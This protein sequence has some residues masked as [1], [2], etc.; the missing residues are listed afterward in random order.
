MKLKRAKAYR[1]LMSYLQLNFQ[2][3][4][5]YQVLVDEEIVLTA[6]SSK[7]DLLAGLERTLQGKCKVL[8]SQCAIEHLYRAKTPEAKEAVK[9][10][11][12]FER[13]RCGHL[14]SKDQDGNKEN[15]TLS[16]FECICECVGPTNKHRYCVATQKPK[17]RARFRDIP[18]IPLI[19]INRA[20]MIMEPMSPA[21]AKVRK[22][23]E[24]SKLTKGLNDFGGVAA[25]NDEE[26]NKN[27]RVRKEK[28]PNPLS[29]KKRQRPVESETGDATD[30]KR[31]K[32]GKRG[33]SKPE[34]KSGDE[35]AMASSATT[36][37]L[38]DQE[39]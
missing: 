20:V 29:I 9:I 22:N 21:T 24:E 32:R 8:I 7:Y 14:P 31:R 18:A 34:G 39:S 19:Y 17:L 10:A 25:N 4:E 26:Q 36:E 16:A 23:I 15:H 11:K 1:K 30:K 35:F 12:T 28:G 33:S 3:R 27:S 38:I 2:F 37:T 5:P 6:A 13:R